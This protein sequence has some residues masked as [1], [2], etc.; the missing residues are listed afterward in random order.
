MLKPFLSA[1][2]FYVAAAASGADA[3]ELGKRGRHFD[4]VLSDIEMPDM[5][6]YEFMR[7]IREANLWQTSQFIALSGHTGAQVIEKV[8][9]AG[10][11]DHVAKFDRMRLLE[12]LKSSSQ[13][14]EAAA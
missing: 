10:F 13:H 9:E 4:V 5:D 14:M 12:I 8:H 7:A 2:G 11:G 1:Q 6:G 3:L